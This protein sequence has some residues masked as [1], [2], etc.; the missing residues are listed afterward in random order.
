MSIEHRKQKRINFA[1][2]VLINDTIM[3]K[4]IDLSEGG[5]Y[6]HTGRLFPIGS[7]VDVL[8]S[9]KGKNI[10]IKAKVQHAQ[11][12]VGMGLQFVVLDAG[13][14]ALIKAFI[15]S[16]SVQPREIKKKT[17]LLVDD[18]ESIRR[19]NKSRLV[20]DG[21]VVLEAPDGIEALKILEGT[22]VDI[23]VLDLYMEK[24][25]GFKLI[26]LIKQMPLLENIP[27]VVLSARSNPE[28][29][30]RALSSGASEF[31]PKMMTSPLKLSEKLKAIFKK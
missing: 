25:D 6:V 27:I 28:E 16:A 3:V 13:Q 31:F 4:G 10:R 5:M 22:P 12:G 21:F 8:I 26:P 19:M 11:A 1:V 30:Q 29:V 18:N 7:E 2:D 24:M 23:V 14:K 20:L 17:V 9:I 15:D